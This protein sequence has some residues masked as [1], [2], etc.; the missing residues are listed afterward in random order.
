MKWP[1]RHGPTIDLA[2]LLLVALG[3]FGLSLMLL[4]LPVKSY[5]ASCITVDV[6]HRPSLA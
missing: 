3:M 2:L 6:L 1:D 4:F 5:G